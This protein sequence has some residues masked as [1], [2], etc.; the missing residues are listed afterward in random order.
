MKRKMRCDLHV[1]LLFVFF[2]FLSVLYVLRQIVSTSLVVG[3]DRGPSQEAI[4]EK[5]SR[6]AASVLRKSPG[7][8]GLCDRE[9]FDR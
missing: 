9:G 8:A 3:E 1:F 7:L 4:P 2:T 6:D 5:S